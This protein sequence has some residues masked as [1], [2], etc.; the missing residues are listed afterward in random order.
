MHKKVILAALICAL[1]FLINGCAVKTYQVTKDRIDQDLTLGNRG[2]LLGEPEAVQA[3][4][5]STTR[6]LQV[7]EL[8]LR[9]PW[10]KRQEA[11]PAVME[12]E[13]AQLE[14]G[15]QAEVAVIKPV[16]G[17]PEALVAPSKVTV[18]KK[19]TVRKGDT[20]QSISRK[21][22]GTTRRWNELYKLNRSRLKNSDKIYPGQVI[23]V[24]VE[25]VRGTK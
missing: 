7:V 11:V 9:Y 3:D 18:I 1:T 24:P 10:K 4:T 5:R 19:Y 22:Y 23:E 17:E 20:L 8:E 16:L 21:F 6:Q 15:Q 2:Y 25:Q 12:P 14:P 13:S